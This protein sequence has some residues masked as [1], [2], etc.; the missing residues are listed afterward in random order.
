VPL[1]SSSNVLSG[2]SSAVAGDFVVV[3][4]GPVATINFNSRDALGEHV[5]ILATASDSCPSGYYSSRD[6]AVHCRPNGFVEVYNGLAL[7]ASTDSLR[8]FL[9][10]LACLIGLF[11]AKILMEDVLVRARMMALAA[12]QQTKKRQ[13]QAAGGHGVTP[14][15]KS[16]AS[17]YTS[18]SKMDHAWVLIASI[19]TS[20]AIWAS[21]CLTLSELNIQQTS[22][23]VDGPLMLTLWLM[24]TPP[25]YASALVKILSLRRSA[26]SEIIANET[27]QES[28]YQRAMGNQPWV[29]PTPGSMP[30]KLSLSGDDQ[31][32]RGPQA[33]PVDSTV[34]GGSAVADST[35]AW[36]P[37]KER[38]S[39]PTLED[40]APKWWDDGATYLR[41][42]L[43]ALRA[44]D[45]YSVLSV[46]I[47]V[48]AYFLIT[49]VGLSAV[50]VQ[51][52]VQWH[53]VVAYIVPSVL[54][55]VLL[56]WM[57]LQLTFFLT[58]G[59]WSSV[60]VAA[61]AAFLSQQLPLSAGV[62]AFYYSTAKL[63]APVAPNSLPI[64]TL[65]IVSVIVVLVASMTLLALLY[66]R[67]SVTMKSVARQLRDTNMA[68][69]RI[70]RN[71]RESKRQLAHQEEK[72]AQLLKLLLL[73]R[74][75]FPNSPT[76]LSLLASAWVALPVPTGPHAKKLDDDAVEAAFIRVAEHLNANTAYSS[77]V[78]DVLLPVPGSPVELI[79]G[80]PMGLPPAEYTSPSFGSMMLPASTRTGS[81]AS[82]VV[83]SLQ[84]MTT[85]PQILAHPVCFNCRTP[86]HTCVYARLGR[87][88]CTHCI[89]C[90]LCLV[91]CV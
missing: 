27:P 15:D 19:F 90:M 54:C 58:S 48:A 78:H 44:T 43:H 33:S 87:V 64:D 17:G 41:S 42:V 23:R 22:V 85:L 39:S 46:L 79:R 7:A 16:D 29:R 12:A 67:N 84:A 83:R 47:K 24:A 37:R 35:L 80:K 71:L 14:A 60:L 3:V 82:S 1:S 66:Y 34:D 52:D 59:E 86:R 91:T 9:G 28:C 32:T 74:L 18:M 76:E 25:M 65:V 45:R 57:S 2:S 6:P 21:L 56:E 89:L 53:A 73:Q 72:E 68:L 31:K 30:S 75:P 63:A 88:S 62:L 4:F 69:Q 8:A 11:V 36:P 40:A 70:Q 38:D 55:V 50:R 51:A 13:Q 81:D 49:G 61:G 5:R 26:I 77:Q 10:F 20:L